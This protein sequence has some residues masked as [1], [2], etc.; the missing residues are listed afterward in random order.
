MVR[1]GKNGDG[2]SDKVQ[3]VFTD[4]DGVLSHILTEATEL[5][6]LP[7]HVPEKKRPNSM[8]DDAGQMSFLPTPSS[9]VLPCFALIEQHE[10]VDAKNHPTKRKVSDAP[11]PCTFP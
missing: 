1:T 3:S 9:L 6:L 2:E 8:R 5:S 4:G 10:R 7:F 11:L